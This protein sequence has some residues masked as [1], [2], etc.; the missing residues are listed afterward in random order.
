MGRTV[1]RGLS[2]VAVVRPEAIGVLSYFTSDGSDLNHVGSN[3]QERRAMKKM[4]LKSVVSEP[5]PRPDEWPV[6]LIVG[7]WRVTG[8]PRVGLSRQRVVECVSRCGVRENVA[9]AKLKDGHPIS[10][11]GCRVGSLPPAHRVG[12]VVH[13]HWESVM[14]VEIL[15]PKQFS[16][17][18]YKQWEQYGLPAVNRVF[19][20]TRWGVAFGWKLFLKEHHLHKKAGR[21]QSVVH[22]RDQ[23]P[24]DRRVTVRVKPAGSEYWFDVI[25]SWVRTDVPATL[26]AAE[27]VAGCSEETS[28]TATDAKP[29]PP[30]PP[31]VATTP[32]VPLLAVERLEKMKGGIERLIEL[33]RDV[34]ALGELRA[35]AQRRYDQASEEV[36]PIRERRD[37]LVGRKAELEEE[38][39]ALATQA[40]ELRT[41]L[42]RTESELEKVNDQP[43]RGRR[44][45]R[46]LPRRLRPGRAEPA[47]SGG[48]GAGA[49]GRHPQG[50]RH[51]TSSRG[52]RKTQLDARA[53]TGH[54]QRTEDRMTTDELL[55][56]KPGDRVGHTECDFLLFEVKKVVTD[57]GEEPDPDDP[58]DRGTPPYISRVEVSSLRYGGG[59]EFMLDD[60]RCGFDKIGPPS[61]IVQPTGWELTKKQLREHNEVAASTFKDFRLRGGHSA[62]YP[63]LRRW[64]FGHPDH[65]NRSFDLVTW[66]GNLITTGDNGECWW[67]RSGDMLY[68]AADAIRSI[69]YFAEKVIREM[70]TE[71]PCG[72]QAKAWVWDEYS[73]RAQEVLL[74]SGLRSGR[75]GEEDET[76]GN[77]KETRDKLL[78]VADEWGESPAFMHHLYHDTNWIDGC[79]PPSVDRYT[80]NFLWGRSAVQVALKLLGYTAG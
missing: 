23:S 2:A 51:L 50:G 52:S 69:D 38:V 74:G 31:P 80:N 15:N 42:G 13:K 55:A 40:A 66:P 27:V 58:T 60:S 9:L 61:T 73:N 77:L 29:V 8:K 70:P 10:C 65:G 3:R 54:N 1:Q 18:A 68:W 71:E 63:G 79:D 49:V 57:P 75:W 33:N 78:A 11:S 47:G 20:G 37:E 30:T 21:T 4:L 41:K 19:A 5:N 56:L 62:V 64:R 45:L 7:H 22:V 44:P 36:L 35:D 48:D 39:A 6:G 14:A 72:E 24:G 26:V 17:S 12:E 32:P 25:V 53:G 34:T 67:R 16:S 59:F 28:E 43:E 76:L 46:P